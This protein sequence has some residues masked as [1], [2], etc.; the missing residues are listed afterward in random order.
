[1]IIRLR[2]NVHQAEAETL[3]SRTLSERE[4]YYLDHDP[5]G[6]LVRG[7]A[8]LLTSTYLNHRGD[9]LIS[10]E[11]SEDDIEALLATRL[12]L[13]PE[14]TMK[15]IGRALQGFSLP[16]STKR[17]S[18]DAPGIDGIGISDRRKDIFQ[19]LGM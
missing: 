6:P 3:V 1:M 11:L 16:T 15:S 2:A 18:P 4:G 13:D 19:G 5:K 9:F 17:S 8:S 14:R 12:K 10:V 7:D